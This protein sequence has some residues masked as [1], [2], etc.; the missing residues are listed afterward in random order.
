MPGNTTQYVQGR[1]FFPVVW[2]RANVTNNEDFQ[3]GITGSAAV[4]E[5]PAARKTDVVT[6]VLSL[7]ALPSA[8]TITVTITK[9][10]TDTSFSAQCGAPTS[11]Q[12][13]VVEIDPGDLQ[14]NKNHRIGMHITS[15]SNLS[16]TT[17]EAA[18]YVEVQPSGE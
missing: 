2:L 12:R 3:M 8:G 5:F 18:A 6:L 7:N 16:P 1:S 13:R 9:D 10:G 15:S 17:I 4:K 14:F 11:T